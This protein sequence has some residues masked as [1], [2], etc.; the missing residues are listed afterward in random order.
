[1]L[2]LIGTFKQFFENVVDGST[3]A[4]AVLPGGFKPPTKGH[5]NALKYLLTDA[6]SGVVFIGNKTR[7]GIGP[8]A[9][10]YIWKIYSKYLPKPIDIK[11][12]NITPVR[13]VYEFADQN[14]GKKIIV[15]A[16]SK[17][18][19]ISRFNYFNRNVD[20]YPLVQVVKIP[21]QSNN[22]SGTLTREKIASNIDEALMYF[23]PDEVKRNKA[24]V[25]QIKHLLTTK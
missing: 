23:L 13:S 17:D 9:A 11:I 5:F 25:A 20:K 22:I 24:D 1:M 3:T 18:E 15:G 21:M 12:S 16:G 10:E 8:E 6:T 2:K 4:V 7:D 14:L 19:D